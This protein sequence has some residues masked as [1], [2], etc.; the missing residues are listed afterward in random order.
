MNREYK[1]KP[2]PCG[3][4]LPSSWN[5][6]ARGIALCRTCVRCHTR[7]MDGYRYDVLHNPSYDVDEHI[8]EDY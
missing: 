2:C 3:S 1:Q 7:M 5:Y 4:G 8:E 6:D